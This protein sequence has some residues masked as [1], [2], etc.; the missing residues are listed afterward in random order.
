MGPEETWIHMRRS[1][2]YAKKSED[3]KKR[4]TARLKKFPL[5]KRILFYWKFDRLRFKIQMYEQVRS[6][7][8]AMALGLT[9]K[10][11]KMTGEPRDR[12]DN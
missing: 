10:Y 9:K 5:W 2:M 7:Y 4:A 11:L 8:V 3:L 6:I 12:L 1:W